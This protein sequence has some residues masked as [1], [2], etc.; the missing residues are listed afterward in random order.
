MLIYL[1]VLLGVLYANKIAGRIKCIWEA[2]ARHSAF[3]QSLAV[4]MPRHHRPRRRF[5]TVFFVLSNNCDR[6][7]IFYGFNIF[8]KSLQMEQKT[9]QIQQIRVREEGVS[10]ELGKDLIRK[11]VSMPSVIGLA[12]LILGTSELAGLLW[13]Q[14][15][16]WNPDSGGWF[17]CCMPIRCRCGTLKRI[18]IVWLRQEY[19]Q[20]SRIRCKKQN[21][22]KATHACLRR[23]FDKI[24]MNTS[25]GML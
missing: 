22:L 5:L 19:I 4:G 23:E 9:R 8:A 18:K 15:R 6:V 2:A 14:S 20:I 21:K 12:L 16:A 25:V 13:P 24:C 1:P 11:D 3:Y 10:E 17:T 7:I